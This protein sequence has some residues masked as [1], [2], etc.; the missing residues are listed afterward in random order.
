MKSMDV[1]HE[2]SAA[3]SV[4]STKLFTC[5]GFHSLWIL[6]QRWRST[7]KN[8]TVTMTESTAYEAPYLLSSPAPLRSEST[9]RD[10]APITPEKICSGP[11]RRA[12]RPVR[13]TYLRAKRVEEEEV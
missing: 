10:A 2:N 7:S 12:K 3:G 11:G 1:V 13:P 9:A 5:L 4:M 8:T 6:R